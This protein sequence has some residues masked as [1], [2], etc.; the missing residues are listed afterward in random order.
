MRLGLAEGGIRVRV[1]V[2]LLLTLM[3]L[4]LY[5]QED[6]YILFRVVV[7]LDCLLSVSCCRI[8]A[9]NLAKSCPNDTE[10]NGNVPDSVRLRHIC[11]GMKP[12]CDPGGK[13]K[14]N[15]RF[16]DEVVIQ[17]RLVRPL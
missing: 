10:M 8:T 12:P 2:R 16:S 7:A 17:L 14:N 4:P 5:T 11:R 15:A 6:A 9:K 13:K 1:R 3:P